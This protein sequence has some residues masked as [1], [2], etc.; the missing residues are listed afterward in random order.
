MNVPSEVFIAIIII[1]ILVLIVYKTRKSKDKFSPSPDE[2]N[3]T[4]DKVTNLIRENG[5]NVPMF[6]EVRNNLPGIDPVTYSGVNSLHKN[7]NLSRETF[8]QIA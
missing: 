2:I 4:Y 1:A 6:T 7:N 3:K 8:A 5:G